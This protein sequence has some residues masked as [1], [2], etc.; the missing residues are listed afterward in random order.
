MAAMIA[1]ALAGAPKAAM[2]SLAAVDSIRRL[3][4]SDRHSLGRFRRDS[5]LAGS[6]SETMR[7]LSALDSIASAPQGS[8]GRWRAD[9]AV[10]RAVARGKLA[11]DSLMQDMKRHPLRYIAF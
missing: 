8:V 10:V 4:T 1:S 3:V 5:S 6:V 9:S 7:A 11:L 2:R